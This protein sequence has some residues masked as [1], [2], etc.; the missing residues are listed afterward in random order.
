VGTVVAMHLAESHFK[1]AKEA[2]I[3]L[4]IAGHIV[5]DN[6]GLNLLLDRIFASENISVIEGSGFRRV[7][8]RKGKGQTKRRAY[9]V[10]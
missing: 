4:V 6:L 5:S 3:N 1:K 2:R 7:D 8:R 9:A 10:R